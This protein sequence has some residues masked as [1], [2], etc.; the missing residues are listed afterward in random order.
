MQKSNA[1]DF[2]DI[3]P[4]LDKLTLPDEISARFTV[5]E[6]LADNEYGSTYRLSE[7]GSGKR[8]ALKCCPKITRQSENKEGKLLRGLSHKGLTAFEA[9]YD[10]GET[11]FTLREYAEGMTIDEFM[12]EHNGITPALAVSIA[13]ELC[14]VLSYLHSQPQPIIHRDIKPSNVIINP[15]DR[16]IKLIDFGIARRYSENSETDTENFGTRK[17]S[18]P[19]H[20]GF[21]QTDNRSDLFS[22]GVLLHYMLT[23]KLD[24]Q[25]TGDDRLARIVDKCMEFDPKNRYQ[26]AEALKQALI[27]YKNGT[28][29]RAA[30]AAGIGAALCL[31]FMTGLT[32]GRYTD[33]LRFP[34]V[35]NAGDTVYTFI[36]PLV[37]QNVR[38]ILGKTDGSNVLLSDLD[39]I[40]ALFFIGDYAVANQEQY[41]ERKESFW[42]YP[43][44][45]NLNDLSDLKNMRRLTQLLINGQNLGDITPLASCPE[46]QLLHLIKCPNLSDL[47]PL[48]ALPRLANLDLVECDVSDISALVDMPA[49]RRLVI[50]N[51][52]ISD[53]TALARMENLRELQFLN[54]PVQ[55]VKELGSLDKLEYLEFYDT[56]LRSLDGIEGFTGLMTLS[57]RNSTGVKDFSQLDLLPKL[58]EL[59]VPAVSEPDAAATITRE[60][61]QVTVE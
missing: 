36:D 24:G 39:E 58:R 43:I 8:F 33:F 56:T 16:S 59:I 13:L 51:I 37:E 46:L 26:S 50:S 45:A 61:I 14:D 54:G 41:D 10:D 23:G 15:E 20:Y 5:M 27:R 22:L 19:E 47:S 35:R 12:E 29:K 1:Q 42:D 52:P 4:P 6:C 44:Y 2:K 40:T 3:N 49:L 32:V 30:M 17:F 28:K 34:I 60:D 48:T 53:Y 7:K 38:A 31:M 18:S 57:L 55:S 9:E 11:L 21:T 25:I